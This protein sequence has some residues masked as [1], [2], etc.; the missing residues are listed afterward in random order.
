MP[1]D[2]TP[3]LDLSE[4]TLIARNIRTALDALERS[5]Y[6][7]DFRTCLWGQLHE[8]GVFSG[9]PAKAPHQMRQFLKCSEE[10]AFHLVSSDSKVFKRQILE[11][12]LKKAD[13]AFSR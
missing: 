3:D 2:S 13:P 7:G 12:L 9:P 8:D 5:G 4:N 6:Q 1:F 11:N 10:T